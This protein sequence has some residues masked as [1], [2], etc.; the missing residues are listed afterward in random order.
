M[1]HA[2]AWRLSSSTSG[3]SRYIGKLSWIGR[4]TGPAG[5][6]HVPIVRRAYRPPRISQ[7]WWEPGGASGAERRLACDLRATKAVGETP[8]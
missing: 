4:P 7:Q 5:A 1:R 8:L 2:S 6:A 3:T